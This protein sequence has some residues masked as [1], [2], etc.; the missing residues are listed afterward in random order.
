MVVI[1]GKFLLSVVAETMNVGP[2]S[3]I[4]N[5]KPNSDDTTRTQAWKILFESGKL[6]QAEKKYDQAANLYERAHSVYSQKAGDLG[7]VTAEILMQQALLKEEIG[8]AAS[9]RD[10]Q[11][12]A[13]AV[14]AEFTRAHDAAREDKA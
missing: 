9:A 8:D 14:I 3:K 5:S 1:A 6:A 7:L 4:L 10:L 2:L 11:S 12:K 13:R